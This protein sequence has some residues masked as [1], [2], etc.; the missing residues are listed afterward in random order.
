MLAVIRHTEGTDRDPDP[1]RVC[2]FYDHRIVDLR[3]HPAITG[4]WMGVSIARLGP[5]YVG[6]VSTAAGAYQLI[7]P[8]W[9]GCKLR[10][11]LPNFTASCQ[12]DSALDLIKRR[13]ALPAIEAGDLYAAIALCAPEWA[14]LPGSASGQ[15]E[16]KMAAILQAYSQ[17]GG[18]LA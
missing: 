9:E 13:G 2:C 8:T 16:A 17:A 18:Q 14:S 11:A 4:E 7:R 15:P 6:K 12:D 1:Y 3:D 5:Q 10:L